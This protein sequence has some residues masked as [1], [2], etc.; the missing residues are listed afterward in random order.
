MKTKPQP[1]PLDERIEAFR[2]ELDRY[3]DSKV[4]EMKRECPG[5][6]EVVLRRLIENRAPGC[7]CLQAQELCRS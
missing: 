3:I 5:V 7:P 4:A 1:E 2:A 6:P